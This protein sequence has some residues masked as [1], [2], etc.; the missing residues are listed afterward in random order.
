M[1]KT[2]KKRRLNG[3]KLNLPAFPMLAIGKFLFPSAMSCKSMLIVG[4]SM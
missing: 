4:C 2:L 1:A 3:K